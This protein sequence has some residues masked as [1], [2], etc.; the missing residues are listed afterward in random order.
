MRSNKWLIAVLAT[1]LIVNLLLIGFV[2]GRLSGMGPPPFGP[3][4]TVGFVRLL[5]FLDSD[6]RAAIKPA[7]RAHMGEI[8]PMLKQ[9][10]GNHRAVIDALTTE[11]FDPARLSN[12]LDALQTNL[13]AAQSASHAAFVALATELTPAERQQLAEAMRHRPHHHRAASRP[14]A[15]PLGM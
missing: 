9:M 8:M 11:P 10:R 5:G 14:Q 1:S 7:L 15:G 4:P 6:R 3:D 12:A 13:D 2:V